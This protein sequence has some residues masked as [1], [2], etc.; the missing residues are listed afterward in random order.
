MTAALPTPR[1]VTRYENVTAELFWNEIQPKGEP[2]VLS[3][4]GRDWPVVRQ[5]LSGA[6]AVRDYLGSF[7]LEKPLEMFIAPPEMKGRFFY[8]DDLHGFNFDRRTSTVRQV[9]DLVVKHLGDTEGP[10]FYAGAV[11][12]PHHLPGFGTEHPVPFL[13]EGTDHL[14]SVWIGTRT[15]IA[16]H[17]DLAQNIAVCGAGR[18]RFTFFPIDQVANLYIGPIDFTMAGQPC[19]LVDL[20]DPDLDRFPRYAEAAR[21]ARFADLEAG[22]AV[23]VPSLWIHQVE[24]F[25]PLGLLVNYWWRDGPEYL[26]TPTLTLMHALL[27]L[28]DM[29]R[30]ERDQ[31]RILFDHFIFDEDETTL[32]HIPEDA[33]GVLGDKTPEQL[34]ALRRLLASRLGG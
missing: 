16:P 31:W 22:D 11:N 32:A 26:I 3:G 18:R 6:E 9:L 5:G 19:S 4:L 34:Q 28:R 2:A 7:S 13:P 25:E 17:W 30:R 20:A 27:S 24:S 29:P 10:S 15:R 33:R 23:Y 21:H 14:A 1:P 8:S 12:I